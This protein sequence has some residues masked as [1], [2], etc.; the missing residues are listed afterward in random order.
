M[1]RHKIITPLTPVQE[2]CERQTYKLNLQLLSFLNTQV[3][4]SI[5]GRVIVDTNGCPILFLSEEEAKRYL[6]NM[7]QS[8]E[9]ET[10]IREKYGT[11]QHAD[12]VEK[13]FEALSEAATVRILKVDFTRKR[14]T[15]EE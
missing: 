4:I 2:A 8:P 11:L 14:P 7:F 10:Y 5:K 9:M 3:A 1:G 13:I 15:K 6:A 12:R